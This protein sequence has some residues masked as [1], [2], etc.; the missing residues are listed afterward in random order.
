[1]PKHSHWYIGCSCDLVQS[2]STEKANRAAKLFTC[3]HVYHKHVTL[4]RFEIE[5]HQFKHSDCQHSQIFHQI[6]FSFPPS[7][8]L[9][10]G[11]GGGM[12]TEPQ[13]LA[14]SFPWGQPDQSEDQITTEQADRTQTISGTKTWCVQSP[15]SKKSAAEWRQS[16]LVKIS[17]LV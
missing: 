9:Q 12:E 1:M 15:R 3:C 7:L 2:P 13:E 5:C 4:F 10:Q 17:H 14:R 8:T 11:T 16:S 6:K